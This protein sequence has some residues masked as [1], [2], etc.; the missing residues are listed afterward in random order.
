MKNKFL[1]RKFILTLLSVVCGIA[2]SLSQMGGK[3]A[4]ICSII[5]AVVP[6]LTYIITEGIIDAKAVDVTKEAA[7][8]IITLVKDPDGY[9][10]YSESKA[11]EPANDDKE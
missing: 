8:Q 6:A 2:I 7:N 11:E 3:I 5:S 1:S 9:F 4:L 10:T